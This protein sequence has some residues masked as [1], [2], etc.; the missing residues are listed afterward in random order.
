MQSLTPARHGCNIGAYFSSIAS[1]SVHG[2]LW[3]VAALIGSYFGVW[4]RPLFG[5]SRT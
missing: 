2:W 3:F 1:A 4:A 5:L